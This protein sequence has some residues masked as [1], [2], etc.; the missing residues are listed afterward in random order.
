[1]VKTSR[2][3]FLFL[4]FVLT[5][6]GSRCAFAPKPQFGPQEEDVRREGEE[7][8]Q[9]EDFDPLSLDDDDVA[10]A[11]SDKTSRTTAEEAVKAPP[12]IAPVTEEP[13]ELE[14]VQGYRVQVF[15]SSNRENAQKIKVEAEEIF[16]ERVYVPYDAPY[17]KVRVGDCLTRREAELLLEKA[18]RHGYRDAWVV[19]T[20]VNQ[21]KE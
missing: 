1:M 4:F 16:P 9:V 10:E 7:V 8:E 13:Q 2:H 20:L 11:E 6:F 3:V 17:Y 21:L 18:V 19:R 14:Q 12:D 5:V 15:V